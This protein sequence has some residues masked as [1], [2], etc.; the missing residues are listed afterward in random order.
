[1]WFYPF[2][3]P[4]ALADVDAYE[5]DVEVDSRSK[6]DT[7]CAHPFQLLTEF[8]D[9]HSDR[10]IPTWAFTRLKDLITN[11]G[12]QFMWEVVILSVT[13]MEPYPGKKFAKKDRM[14]ARSWLA[15]FDLEDNTPE[16]DPLIIAAIARTT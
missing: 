8:D 5:A 3:Q 1:M 6:I 10:G 16:D 11:T 15:F 4:E 13:E 9:G 12:L 14:W 2:M 7:L